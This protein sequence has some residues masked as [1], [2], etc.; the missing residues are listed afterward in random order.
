MSYAPRTGSFIAAVFKVVI[1]KG[2]GSESML[3]GA[4][5]NTSVQQGLTKTVV[6]A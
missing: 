3:S 1:D 6:L 5:V 4:R 2:F